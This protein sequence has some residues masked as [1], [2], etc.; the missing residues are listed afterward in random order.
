[1]DCPWKEN[2]KT[3]S[4]VIVK[5]SGNINC[6][7]FS[8]KSLW[9]L[10][11]GKIA[12]K[13]IYFFMSTDFQL[14][15]RESWIAWMLIM[16]FA[17]TWLLAW[18]LTVPMFCVLSIQLRIFLNFLNSRCALLIDLCK[19]QYTIYKICLPYDDLI[20]WHYSL[21]LSFRQ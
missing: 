6:G 10:K 21:L 4:I 7:S 19:C 18:G 20:C 15:N 1:M 3:V 13:K 9:V 5:G 17:V 16:S 8:L 2:S 14:S 12:F 11:L